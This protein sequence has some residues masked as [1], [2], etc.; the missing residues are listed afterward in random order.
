MNFLLLS[1]IHVKVNNI[2]KL[3]S[4][5]HSCMFHKKMKFFDVSFNI[6]K[7]L[8]SYYMYISRMHAMLNMACTQCDVEINLHVPQM[9]H[10]DLLMVDQNQCKLNSLLH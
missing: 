3:L 2:Q 1:S 4:L 5:A 6:Q 10:G 7:C 8:S 9:G